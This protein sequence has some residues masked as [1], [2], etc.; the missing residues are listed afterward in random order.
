MYLRKGG[1]EW[2]VGFGT[3]YSIVP[4]NLVAGKSRN[5]ISH[6]NTACAQQAHP[7]IGANGSTLPAHGKEFLYD[8]KDVYSRRVSTTQHKVSGR[9]LDGTPGTYSVANIH[10]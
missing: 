8:R 2:M 1:L 7:S 5:R 6:V 9:P 3:V 10:H 4:V